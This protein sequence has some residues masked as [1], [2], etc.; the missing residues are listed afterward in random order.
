[1]VSAVF[2]AV[3]GSYVNSESKCFSAAI[4]PD[5]V[6]PGGQIA[7]QAGSMAVVPEAGEPLS[8]QAADLIR[9]IP[10]VFLESRA[11]SWTSPPT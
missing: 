8:P 10:R 4:R 7:Q 1:M 2:A 11:C 6:S 5:S 3:T 9:R